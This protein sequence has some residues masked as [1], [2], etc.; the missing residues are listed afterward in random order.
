MEMVRTCEEDIVLSPRTG[1]PV[2]DWCKLEDR[3]SLLGDDLGS[4]DFA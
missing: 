4:P 3:Q 1:E 2:G